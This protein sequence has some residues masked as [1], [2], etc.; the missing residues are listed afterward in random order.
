MV[1]SWNLQPSIIGSTFM[2]CHFI[3]HILSLLLYIAGFR[4]LTS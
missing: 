2:A 4:I 1:I 3:F